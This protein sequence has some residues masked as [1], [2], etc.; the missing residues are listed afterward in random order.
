VRASLWFFGLVPLGL[1]AIAVFAYPAWLLLTPQFDF[2]FHRIASRVAMLA[3]LLGLLWLIRREG[4]NNRASLGYGAPRAGWLRSSGLA[5]VLGVLTMTP[6]ILAMLALDL[7]NLKPGIELVAAQLLP[8]IAGG[9]GT[10]LAVAF[11]EETFLRGA[12]YSAVARESGPRVAILSTALLYAALHFLAKHRIPADGVDAGSGLEMIQGLLRLFGAPLSI[13]D[14]FL[15]F[16]AVGI[17]LGVVRY[18]TGS[19]AACIGLHAGWV[20]VISVVRE[21]SRADATQP[22]AFLLSSFDGVVGWLVLLWT[23]VLGLGLSRFYRRRQ[24]A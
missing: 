22:L 4:L 23:V 16:F 7:R 10:G 11:I 12:M 3:A 15:S 17:L 2:P 24:L 21:T 18:L 19:I 20:W 5:L 14:A 1:G 13:V 6:V 9:L 8:L